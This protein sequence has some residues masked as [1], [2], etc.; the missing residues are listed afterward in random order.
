MIC[1]FLRHTLFSMFVAAG[2]VACASYGGR[3]LAPG[4]ATLPDVLTTMGEPAMRWQDA[5]GSL[6]LAY[7]RGPEGMHTFMVYLAPDGRLVRI[8]NVLD[9]K[10]FARIVPGISG[11]P[12]V[13]RILGPSTPQ[14]TSY[15]SARDELVWEWL[16]CDSGGFQARFDVL[17]DGQTKLVRSTF[18]RPD[19]RGPDGAV[20]SCGSLPPRD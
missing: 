8:E 18:S 6:Q 12:E 1:K 19:Y 20:L 5:D 15:F 16:Y 3:G 10:H 4:V 11:Q 14:W 13:L 17:F 7:P 2:L 9:E